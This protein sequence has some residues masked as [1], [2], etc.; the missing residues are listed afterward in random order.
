MGIYARTGKDVESDAWKDRMRPFCDS[1]GIQV[2][3]GDA[4]TLLG[5]LADGSVGAV[6][7]DPPYEIMMNTTFESRRWDHQGISFNPAFWAAVRVKTRPGASLFAFGSPRT[8]HHLCDA[9]EEAGW[10]IVDQICRL[11][12]HGMPKGEYADHAVDKALGIKDTRPVISRGGAVIGRRTRVQG[13]YRPVSDQAKVW[14]D[15]NPSLKPAW[16]PIVVAQNPR[17]MPLGD[18]LLA[19][20]G[21]VLH[22]DGTPY[23]SNLVVDDAV[24]MP[25]MP[26]FWLDSH[27]DGRFYAYDDM[28]MRPNDPADDAW[29]GACAVVGL[30][31]TS[32]LIPR[33]LCTPG[34]LDHMSEAGMRHVAHPT[35]K[36]L[37]LMRR[38]VHL[39]GT[40]PILDPFAGSGTTLEAARAEG[41]QAVGFERDAQYLPLI[42]ARLAQPIQDGLL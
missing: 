25:D 41:L 5:R 15:Y 12:P 22:V 33:R 28:M 1:H 18:S 19:G 21:G 32:P 26:R 36:P 24:R 13:A 29:R 42:T 14:A 34:M 30:D 4:M 35:V 10:R 3:H 6:V 31:P 20:H 2:W 9:L 8:W 7:T 39:A 38:I 27:A 16:E 17:V 23:P 37:S 40:S 11:K